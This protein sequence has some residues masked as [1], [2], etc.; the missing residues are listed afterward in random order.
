MIKKKQKD[1]LLEAIETGLNVT[2]AC[3]IANINRKTFYELKKDKDFLKQVEKAEVKL[4]KRALMAIQKAGLGNSWQAMAWLL[5]RK[6][7]DEFGLKT[8]QELTLRA[9]EE[10][11]KQGKI[12]QKLF[13]IK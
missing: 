9:E 5:E 7:N 3:K 10:F 11:K 13:G 1:S 12:L 2:D 4:K 8:K 6:W